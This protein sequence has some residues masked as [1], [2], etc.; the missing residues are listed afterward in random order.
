MF[1]MLFKYPP[2]IFSRGKFVMLSPWPVWLLI[3]LIVAAAAGLFWHVNRSSGVLTRVRSLAIWLAQAALVA[4]VLFML[5]R[6][7][8]SVARLRP[9]QNVVAV[10]MDHSRS[11]AL[12]EDGKNICYFS[13]DFIFSNAASIPPGFFP[14]AVA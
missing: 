7:A 5:W 4:I 3:L 12:A 6:P 2:A 8:I 9:Q 10:L 11:M 14:P 13:S 1:E